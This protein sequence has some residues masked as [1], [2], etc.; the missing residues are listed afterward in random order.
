MCNLSK[1]AKGADR[2][3]HPAMAASP[4]LFRIIA[5]PCGAAG[6]SQRRLLL[7]EPDGSQAREADTADQRLHEEVLRLSPGSRRHWG[8][9][10]CA[11][12]TPAYNW[13]QT[14]IIQLIMKITGGS[15]DTS[16]DIEFTDWERVRS[17]AREFWSK[18]SGNRSRVAWACGCGAFCLINRRLSHQIVKLSF[19]AIFPCQI[20]SAPIMRLHRHGKRQ[21][22]QA[23]R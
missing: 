8:V 9:R 17:F 4:N 11:A 3:F 16:K 20:K 15:T 19:S 10:R 2:R 5:Y 12:D 14:R 6:S 13:W 21:R 22:K 18:D 1:Y 7:R 23:G